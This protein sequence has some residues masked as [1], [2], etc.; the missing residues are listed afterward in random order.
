M[1]LRR[2]NKRVALSHLSIYCT[3]K[4]IK[5]S[6]RSDKN[7]ILETKWNV[8]FKLPGAYY[9]VSNIEVYFGY[10]TKNHE[11]R[12]NLQFKHT[13]RKFETELHSKSKLDTILNFRYMKP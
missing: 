8:E 12:I 4:N 7:R 2:C 3:W 11:T 1:N 6:Y 9:S 5:K 10:T 13:S